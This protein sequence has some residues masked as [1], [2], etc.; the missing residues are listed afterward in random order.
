[1]KLNAATA[2]IPDLRGSNLTPVRDRVRAHCEEASPYAQNELRHPRRHFMQ[3]QQVRKRN[4][5]RMDCKHAGAT[6]CA[7]VRVSNAEG[8][9]F[10]HYLSLGCECQHTRASRKKINEHRGRGRRSLE[11]MHRHF[12]CTISQTQTQAYRSFQ[13]KES[14][15][16]IGWRTSPTVCPCR[17]LQ[18]TAPKKR[19]KEHLSSVRIE[20]TTSSV[21]ERR[22]YRCA[23]SSPW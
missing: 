22:D 15:V 6:Y 10:D 21:S 18:T 19:Q 20:L 2:C 8:W 3:V 23:T 7:V 13:L 4:E 11:I 1:V 16:R 14:S 17:A 5:S 12:N 9:V